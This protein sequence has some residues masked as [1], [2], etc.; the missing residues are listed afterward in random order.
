MPTL[1]LVIPCYNEAATIQA[2]IAAVR[3]LGATLRSSGI[4]IEVIAV[5]DA[6]TDRT[7]TLLH[8]LS[9]E[10]DTLR[11]V[12]HPAN[13]GKGGAIQT[14]RQHV[15]GDI[16]VIQDADL[17]Y[18]PTDIPGLIRPILQGHADA[19]LGTRF[20]GSGAHRV[21]Y[22][23]HRIGNGVLTLLSNTFTNLNVTDMETG[24]K[25]FTRQVFMNM[26]LTRARF[27]IEPEIVARLGQM[28]ARVYEVPINYYGRT[29]A[30]GKKI[31]WRD[32]I[33]AFWHIVHAHVTA[34]AQPPLP[35]VPRA[36]TGHVMHVE[37]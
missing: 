30:E 32:G 19:V 25:A 6:S 24:Y 27:G 33:A 36:S 34:Q 37:A 16:V 10:D 35:S 13:R 20:G 18:D 5:D 12:S 23:W 22:F 9:A 28:G 26:H 1:T 11:V 7:Q 2:T 29:Y 17:E 8:E 21:L 4:A 15:T 14:A 3:T 31:T